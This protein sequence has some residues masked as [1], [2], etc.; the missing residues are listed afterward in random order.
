MERRAWKCIMLCLVEVGG[1]S[2][3]VSLRR[4]TVQSSE[5]S[6]SADTPVHVVALCRGLTTKLWNFIQT[7][8]GCV[9]RNGEQYFVDGFRLHLCIFLFSCLRNRIHFVNYTPTSLYVYRRRYYFTCQCK[10]CSNVYFHKLITNKEYWMWSNIF[11]SL[12]VFVV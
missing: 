5:I 1:W 10:L 11:V 3:P 2:R 8:L 4:D 12:F 7:G 6:I 9:N